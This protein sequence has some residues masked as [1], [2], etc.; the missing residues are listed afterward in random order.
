MGFLSGVVIFPWVWRR[1]PLSS[2][3]LQLVAYD[4]IS[5]FLVR[6]MVIPNISRSDL[7]ILVA[8]SCIISEFDQ[9]TLIN[10]L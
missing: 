6:D 5:V 1:K 4:G 10:L 2:L 3:F 8:I 9:V 7:S